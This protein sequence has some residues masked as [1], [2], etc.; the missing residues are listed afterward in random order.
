MANAL[1]NAAT[2]DERAAEEF[3]ES[4]IKRIKQT[5]MLRVGEEKKMIEMLA[6]MKQAGMLKEDEIVKRSI[7]AMQKY[8]K[9]IAEQMSAEELAMTLSSAKK[10]KEAELDALAERHREEIAM[11]IATCF[12]LRANC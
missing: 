3:A 12:S 5:M 4:Q 8:R 6:R 7:L 10:K 9:A 1:N 2:A 11:E